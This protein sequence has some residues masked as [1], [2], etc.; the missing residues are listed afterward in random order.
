MS[1][2]K[3]SSTKFACRKC[4]YILGDDDTKCPV[5]GGSDLSDDWS[6]LIVIID[7]SSRVA[8]LMGVKRPGRYAIKVR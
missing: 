2:E 1:K 7:T 8:E 4:K 3:P 6:G 5:C